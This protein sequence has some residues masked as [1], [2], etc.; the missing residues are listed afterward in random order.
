MKDMK[1]LVDTNIIMDA[2]TEREPFAENSK[3]VI[4]IFGENGY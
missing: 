2:L 4:R 3:K 1:A